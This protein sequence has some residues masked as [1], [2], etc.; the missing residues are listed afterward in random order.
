[1][2]PYRPFVFV[3]AL[4]ATVY[5]IGWLSYV[6]RGLLDARAHVWSRN[7]S[8]NLVVVAIDPAS[9]HALRHLPWPWPRRHHAEVLKRL[10]AAGADRIAFDFDFSSSQTP[11]DDRALAEALALAGPQRVALAVHRQLVRDHIFDTA[12]VQTF[13]RFAT[14]ASIN[15]R[16]D[17]EGR[18]RAIQTVSAFA[19]KTVPTMSAWLAGARDTSAR[20]IM[21][22]FSI[23]PA[24][25]PPQHWDCAVSRSRGSA[26]T[27]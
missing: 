4:I 21:I 5:L 6:D 2:R 22:D 14:R 12:P 8:G 9:L 13:R 26:L 7:A 27:G 24:T 1:M 25:I 15:V 16:P 10:L 3:A 18:I 19:D 11:Q 20:E 17:P 23:D